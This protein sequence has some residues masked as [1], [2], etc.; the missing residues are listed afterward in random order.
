MYIKL[1]NKIEHFFDVTLAKDVHQFK[2][3]IIAI[4][5]EP[6]S[7][8]G[9]LVAW[10]L[11]LIIF[12]AIV[13]SCIAKI[14]I[15]ATAT[16]QIVPVGNTKV[17]QSHID[18]TI[19]TIKIKEG[20]FVKKGDLLIELDDESYTSEKESLE[21][22]LAAE[23]VKYN[24][25]NAMLNYLDKKVVE[26]LVLVDGRSISPR[27]QEMLYEQE[28]K[29]LESSLIMLKEMIDQKKY[30]LE[31]VVNNINHYKQ[32]VNLTEIRAKKFKGLLEQKVSSELEYMEFD[33]KRIREKNELNSLIS[34]ERQTNANIKELEEKVKYTVIENK[35]RQLTTL[36]E[37]F[38][39]INKLKEEIN[40]NE[41]M[42]K[43]SKIISPV[44]GYIQE[45]KF[46]TIGGVMEQAQEILKIVEDKS[47]IEVETMI[48]SKDIGFV[49]R[50]MEVAIKVD[51][52]LFTKYGLVH[53]TVINISEDAIKDEKMGLVY[54][55][56][57]KLNEKTVHV[58][59]KE[60]DLSYGMGVTSEIKTGTRTVMEFFLSPIM[61]KM[62]ESINER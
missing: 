3:A 36:E 27:I 51:S 56:K 9:R 13:W 32:T 62:N 16:G 4:Q 22:M 12:I 31:S 2:P 10:T 40:K 7:P 55:T 5:D 21:K 59:G 48:L 14:D 15:I 29:D 46:H 53:G 35:K 18:A 44:D 61:K 52:F 49:H 26:K 19:R 33:E 41:I 47:D 57:I 50:G 17:V 42:I 23:T 8:A 37:S 1:K 39:N 45:L 43:Y 60:I 28:Y 24:R 11:C 30:E 6:A 34:R 54:K 25:A 20:D 58:E 38:N